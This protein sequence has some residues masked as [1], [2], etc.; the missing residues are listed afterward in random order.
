MAERGR[1][2]SFDRDRA[3]RRAMEVFWERG[4]EGTSLG[5]LTAA[6]G[7]N[8]PSLY[9]AFGCKEELFQEAIALYDAVEGRIAS[10]A[11]EEAPTARAAVEGM[12]RANVA[13]F[14][15]P[16]KP[17]GCMIVNS[18]IVGRPDNAQ[19]RAFLARCRGG[20][21]AALR[22]RLERG[23]AEG[24]IPGGA[25]TAAMADFYTTVLQGLSIQAR[26]GASRERLE[27]IIESAM[28]AWRTMIAP[29]A[30]TAGNGPTR[31]GDPMP[32]AS[33]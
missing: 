33:R 19:I 22:D 12:L 17:S 8:R 14:A 16:Q 10:R 21:V 6:M 2:R 31:V 13:V 30:D 32:R 7:I 4:Y 29:N 26:D 11:L 28:S 9:A 18:S 23:V 5:D 15:D 3:L 25:D 20:S 27:S 24:D 1:P